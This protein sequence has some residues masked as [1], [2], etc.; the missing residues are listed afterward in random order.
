MLAPR[1]VILSHK[2]KSS[3]RRKLASYKPASRTACRQTFSDVSVK[4]IEEACGNFDAGNLVT[5]LLPAFAKR[6]EPIIWPPWVFIIPNCGKHLHIKN[7]AVS[8]ILAD[9]GGELNAG[10]SLDCCAVQV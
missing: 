2:S 1:C 7:R 9:S 10:R 6:R 8:P 5:K 3:E 4:N